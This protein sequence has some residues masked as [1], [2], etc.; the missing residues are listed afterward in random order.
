MKSYKV[1]VSPA[2][3]EDLRRRIAYLVDIKKNKKA[4]KNVMA[5]YQ[6]TRKTLSDIAGSIRVPDSI[7]LQNRDLKRINF[8]RHDYFML[9]RIDG[10]VATITNI[11]HSYEDYENKL[12]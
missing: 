4:A 6:E 10:D 3:R 5:D 1:K 7:E 2:A 9:F 12:G 8:R 11:F